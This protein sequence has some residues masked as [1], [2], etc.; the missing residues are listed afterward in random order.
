MD[1]RNGYHDRR[2]DKTNATQHEKAHLRKGSVTQIR[3]QTFLYL[4]SNGGLRLVGKLVRGVPFPTFLAMA[5]L[6]WST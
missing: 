2:S 5:E 1:V 6:V 3:Y 4:R